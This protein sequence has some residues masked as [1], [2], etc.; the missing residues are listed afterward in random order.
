MDNFYEISNM[1]LGYYHLFA[2]K[3]WD[4]KSEALPK[5]VVLLGHPFCLNV[6][7]FITHTQLVTTVRMGFIH[8]QYG[9]EE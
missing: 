8:Y 7:C 9:E 1:L 4:L 5:L 3:L 2:M 6:Y